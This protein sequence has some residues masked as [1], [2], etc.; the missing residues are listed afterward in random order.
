MECRF[1]ETV[2]VYVVLWRQWAAIV[3]MLL[4]VLIQVCVIVRTII[5]VFGING[6]VTPRIIRLCG[7][8]V[9]VL[10]IV[11]GLPV[12]FPCIDAILFYGSFVLHLATLPVGEERVLYALDAL[13]V[14]IEGI[15]LFVGLTGVEFPVFGFV[16]HLHGCDVSILVVLVNLAVSVAHDAVKQIERGVGTHSLDVPQGQTVLCFIS[17]VG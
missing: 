13:P 11:G 14:G 3:V 2:V 1:Q 7:R 4:F 15:S 9:A 8:E 10:A 16:V 17:P 5:F 12:S 6:L